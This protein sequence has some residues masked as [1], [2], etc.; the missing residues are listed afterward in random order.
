M[1]ASVAGSTGQT[2]GIAITVKAGVGAVGQQVAVDV[3]DAV[4]VAVLIPPVAVAEGAV[5]VTVVVLIESGLASALRA[6]GESEYDSVLVSGTFCGKHG[7][8]CNN[9]LS[10]PCAASPIKCSK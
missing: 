6:G 7:V 2:I 3:G 5:A 4:G 8:H 10:R 9:S 1:P